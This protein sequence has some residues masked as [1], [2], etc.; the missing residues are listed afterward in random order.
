MGKGQ[1]V[2][3][4]NLESQKEHQKFIRGSERW[5]C[6]KTTSCSVHQKTEHWKEHQ[7]TKTVKKRLLAFWSFLTL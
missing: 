4:Q 3:N 6:E 1:D 5:K 2:K 7:K